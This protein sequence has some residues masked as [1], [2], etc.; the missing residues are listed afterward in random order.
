MARWRICST[1]IQAKPE[2]VEKIVLATIA[3]LRYIITCDKL[4]TLAIVPKVLLIA[5][6]QL[7]KLFLDIGEGTPTLHRGYR[8]IGVIISALSSVRKYENFFPILSL[9]LSPRLMAKFKLI[10]KMKVI[11]PSPPK[12]TLSENMWPVKIFS[13]NFLTHGIN[14]LTHGDNF[15]ILTARN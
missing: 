2:T 3:H 14:L 1:T 9:K 15:K 11:P 7:V 4:T 12:L 5:K 6:D 10:L 8:L 13:V